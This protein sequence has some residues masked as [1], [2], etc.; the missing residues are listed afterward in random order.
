[1]DEAEAF[2]AG[3]AD[4]EFGFQG[5]DGG[6]EAEDLDQSG[7]L[8]RGD[9]DDHEGAAVGGGEVAAEGAEQVVAE[10]GAVLA[11]QLHLGDLAQMADAGDG[12]VG[13]GDADVLALSGGAPGAFGGN[14]GEG[15]VG[16][17]WST[18]PVMSGRPTAAL[19]V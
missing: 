12:D 11:S 18:G 9:G 14:E 16:P 4:A 2:V 1:M 15:G 13:E 7:P 6:G 17:G 8:A 5:G 19:T 3:E 10:A